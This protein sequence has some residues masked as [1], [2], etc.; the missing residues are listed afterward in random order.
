M[1]HW[2]LQSVASWQRYGFRR[3]TNKQTNKWTDR[4]T[5]KSPSSTGP[6]ATCRQMSVATGHWSVVPICS[7]FT[8]RDLMLS[9]RGLVL[10]NPCATRLAMSITMEACFRRRLHELC[11]MLFKELRS[12]I[13]WVW[14]KSW[15]AAEWSHQN[16]C[17]W[18][19]PLQEI[20]NNE[21]DF[22]T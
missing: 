15:K 5:E 14:L 22:L 16:D 7:Y 6:I 17:S 21:I 1:S 13:W 19:I 20:T 3:Q 18:M 4:W 9:A 8:L 12:S 11:R 10:A 2:L